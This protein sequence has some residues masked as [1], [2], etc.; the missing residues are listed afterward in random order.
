[1]SEWKTGWG[2]HG[3][4][5]VFICYFSHITLIF[6]QNGA[7]FVGKYYTCNGKVTHA[8]IR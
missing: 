8:V 7:K 6:G 4:A 5:P 1:M 3:L 2:R